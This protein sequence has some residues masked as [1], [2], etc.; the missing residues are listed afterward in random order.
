MAEPIKKGALGVDGAL[1]FQNRMLK[2]LQAGR[3]HQAILF[4][5]EDK[6][7]RYEI[8]KS[9][10]KFIFCKNK[11][12]SFCNECSSCKRIEKELHPDFLILKEPEE[13]HLKIETVRE[14]CHQ[15]EISPIEGGPKICVIED[16]HR[17]NTASSNAF[18][19]TLEEPGENRYFFLLTHQPHLLLPTIL[20]RCIQFTLK[21]EAKAFEYSPE[22]K[23]RYSDLLRD[24]MRTKNILSLVEEL[25]SKEETLG[26]L[27]FLQREMH[28]AVTAKPMQENFFVALS[29]HELTRKYASVLELEGRLRSNANYGLMLETLLRQDFIGT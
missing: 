16:A 19:K 9:A 20:S 24:A 29:P 11:K 26:F 27:Q 13:D 12:Q 4:V 3:I 1:T 8:T 10:V 17:L 15:M 14:I 6:Q 2:Y 21:P 28:Q 18:L 22:T 23:K 5:G 25:D 7:V